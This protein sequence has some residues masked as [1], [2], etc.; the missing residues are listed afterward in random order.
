MRID[1]R[2][3]EVITVERIRTA[4]V[5][6][7]YFRLHLIRGKQGYRERYYTITTV[8]GWKSL[9]L[10]KVVREGQ[11]LPPERCQFVLADGSTVRGMVR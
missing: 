3:A 1:I 11:T 2:C 5:D 10:R 9:A 6:I 4:L 8:R 7:H